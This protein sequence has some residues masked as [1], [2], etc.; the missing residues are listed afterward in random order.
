MIESEVIQKAELLETFP[1]IDIFSKE[2]I[3]H[4]YKF[5]YIILRHKSHNTILILLIRCLF[6]LQL[7]QHTIYGTSIKKLKDDFFLNFL[8]VIRYF[9]VPHL[10]INSKKKYILF[11]SCSFCYNFLLIFLLLYLK[12]YYYKNFNIYIIQFLGFLNCL[13]VNYMFCPLINIFGLVFICEKDKHKYLDVKCYSDKIH[14]IILFFSLTNLIFIICYSL[15]VIIHFNEIG[16]IKI[17]GILRRTNSYFEFICYCLSFIIYIIGFIHKNYYESNKKLRIYI[18]IIHIF[19]GLTMVFYLN[20]NVYFYKFYLN[21]FLSCGFSFFTWLSLIL[22]ICI[23]TST[24]HVVFTIIIGWLFIF[25]CMYFLLIFKIDYYLFQSNIFENEKL[26]SIEI[27][28]SNF[29]SLIQNYKINDKIYIHGII[30]SFEE[31]LLNYQEEEELYQSLLNNKYMEEKFG[32][33]SIVLKMNCIIYCIY[34]YFMEKSAYIKDDMLLLFCYFLV[35]NLKNPTYTIYLC[36]KKKI[37]G[38]KNNYIKYI[39]M[40]DIKEY[41]IDRLIS[42][43]IKNK[44]SIKHIEITKVILFNKYSEKLRLKI[45]DAT[46]SQA[47]YFTFLKSPTEN[48]PNK[49]LELGNKILNLRKEILNLWNEIINLNPF[50]DDIQQ[51]F[52]MYLDNII[53]DDELLKKSSKEFNRIREIK[54]LEKNNKYHK[55][56]NIDNSCILLFDGFNNSGKL[57][58]YTLNF[59]KIF[60]IHDSQIINFYIEDLVPKCISTFHHKLIEDALEYSNLKNIFGEEKNISIQINDTL[61]N[62]NAYV[63][64]LPSFSNGLIFIIS[65]TK[66][67]TNQFLILL[68]NEFKI[69]SMSNISS[70]Q[71]IGYLNQKNYWLY[72]Y[73]LS[74]KVIGNHIATLIPEFLHL[75]QYK[76]N[77][78]FIENNYNEQKGNIYSNVITTNN[79]QNKLNQV[80]EQIKLNGRLKITLKGKVNSN[81]KKKKESVIKTSTT[82]KS[83]ENDFEINND[84][85]AYKDFLYEIKNCCI[86]KGKSIFFRVI[87]RTYFKE[88]YSFY[89]VFIQKDTSIDLNIKELDNMNNQKKKVLTETK[90]NFEIPEKILKK[91][92]TFKKQITILGSRLHIN[93]EESKLNNAIN[94]HNKIKRYLTDLGQNNSVFL[95]NQILYSSIKE[96]VILKKTPKN[97]IF[98]RISTF[99]FSIL[100]L[101][102]IINNTKSLKQN[103]SNIENFLFQNYF[104]NYT[105]HFTS[106]LYISF[107]NFQLIKNKLIPNDIFNQEYLD[108]TISINKRIINDLINEINEFPKFSDEYN[109]LIF[110]LNSIHYFVFNY[111]YSITYNINQINILHFLISNSLYFLNHTQ[112]Y[113]DENFNNYDII[114]QNIIDSSF[115]YS[116]SNIY[117]LNY[118]QIKHIINTKSDYKI[119]LIYIIIHLILFIIF[120]L[121]F[122]WIISKRYKVKKNL[123]QRMINFQTEEFNFYIKYIEEVSKKLNNDNIEE[124]KISEEN[125]NNIEGISYTQNNKKNILKNLNYTIK[126]LKRKKDKKGQDKEKRKKFHLLQL[127]KKQK[128]KIL[129]KYY[130]FLEFFSSIKYCGILFLFMTYYIVI[131]PLYITKKNDFLL[132]DNRITKIETITIATYLNYIHIKKNI[133]NYISFIIEKQFCYEEFSLGKNECTLSNQIVSISNINNFKFNFSI[134]ENNIISFDNSLY[135]SIIKDMNVQ[136]NLIQYNLTKLYYGNMCDIIIENDSKIDYDNCITFWDSILIQGLQQSIIYFFDLQKEI[137]FTFFY[138]KEE[139]N[140]SIFNSCLESLIG[141]ENYLLIYFYIAEGYSDDLL[142]IIKQNKKMEIIQDLNIVLYF[143]IFIYFLSYVLIFFF[144]EQIKNNFCTFSNFMAIFPHKYVIKDED[145]YNSLLS[146]KNFY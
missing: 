123:I 99:F 101:I 76:N 16:G 120:F 58:Y 96:N 114:L 71:D 79:I 61:F 17:I 60:L 23:L 119:S 89:K 77:K 86:N 64:C 46:Q 73:N 134:F 94:Q 104:F 44:D 93:I 45:F 26:E 13:L 72:P 84:L 140:L 47:D 3:H 88:Q 75:I 21:L 74:P 34:H 109:K 78:F 83:I 90:I 11:L 85:I 138:H 107:T 55:L 128:Q 116:F 91:K 48:S 22:L 125:N 14:I 54:L 66:E 137:L 40:K 29:N 126:D 2:K 144:I 92:K 53:Q 65:I 62:I 133:I 59:P 97:I 130:I 103:F 43:K 4:I 106:C 131:Y 105:I 15:L 35:N 142:T 8:Y 41:M 52:I 63:K 135:F 132:Y 19:Y 122:L 6:F 143:F 145:F 108:N 57:L 20:Y 38:Y 81:I 110:K 98:L 28:I 111:N 124:I 100:S 95:Q 27:F 42:N 87:H 30:N 70:H 18:K 68:D 9:V 36:S 10:Y 69:N 39:L 129:I 12:F 102:I 56:F 32:K 80:Y 31:Y 113:F 121:F 5:F 33:N 118:E 112:D 127:Q 51:D 115:N 24:A 139:N 141:I 117:G 1:Y 136:S 25:I 49:F 146:M 50:C 82:F 67:N 37:T 7:M